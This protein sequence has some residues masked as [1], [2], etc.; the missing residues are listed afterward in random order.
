M[1]RRETVVVSAVRTPFGRMGGT[2]SSIPAVDLGAMAIREV[3][4]RAGLQGREDEIDY[5]YMGMVV[6]AGAGQIPSRQA[7]IKA[8]LPPEVPSDTL[9]KVCASSLRAANIGDMMIRLGEADTVIAGGMENMSLGPY[10]LERARYGYRLGN[11]KL[12]DATVHDGLWCG[13]K[14][15]HMGV[16]GSDV[17]MELGVSREQQD[18]WAYR[19][20]MRVKEAYENGKFA[21]ELMPVRIPQRKGNALVFDG[22]EHPR[23][24]TTPEGLAALRPVFG[25]DG[26]VTAGNAP[27]INDGA[28]ALVLMSRDKATELGATPLA[29]IISHG[30]A[31]LD[32]PYLA[33][34]PA[35]AGK[36]ALEK[37]G[38]TVSDLDLI[39][40]NEAFASVAITSMDMLGADP[41]IVNVNGGA[42]AIGH[43]I[44]ASGARILMTLIYELR[45]RGGG[46]GLTTICSGAAQGEATLVRV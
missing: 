35:L 45:R 7:T 31:S 29:T 4:D 20:Q 34:V 32:A 1:S 43:P 10:F 23:S 12:V 3:V 19:S 26:T 17:A 24:D 30:T 9:N 18:Q 40:I 22:D 33:K 28:A 42:I 13:I 27:G 5:V 46:L 21:D 44:G 36:V 38:M 6:Q 15:V 8:G 37:A 16:H 41:E 14:D 2:L 25:A 39:E 11:G